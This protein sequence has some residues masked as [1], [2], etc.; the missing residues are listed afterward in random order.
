MGKLI[1]SKNIIDL[2]DR[3]NEDLTK[4]WAKLVRNHPGTVNYQNYSEH[5]LFTR[6]RRVYL[7]LLKWLSEDLD[8][9]EVANIYTTLG[10]ERCL[11]G[12]KL[13]EVVQALLL[14]RRV[15]WFEIENES[16]M[17]TALE[18]NLQIEMGDRVTAFFDRAIFY[19]AQGFES[20]A[21]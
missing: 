20:V 9:E 10:K 2:L 21:K 18:L 3:H 1:V 7:D 15:L 8:D 16:L 5:K 11:E 13:S 4:K 6:Y 19:T 14:I 17:D 12:F